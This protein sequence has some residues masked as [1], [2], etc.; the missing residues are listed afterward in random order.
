MELV[1]RGLKLQAQ[2]V[3]LLIGLMMRFQIRGTPLLDQ[4]KTNGVRAV[5]A[6]PESR[7][8]FLIDGDGNEIAPGPYYS[9]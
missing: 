7:R 6:W 4:G 2:R 9:D 1:E 5:R 8:A 3:D